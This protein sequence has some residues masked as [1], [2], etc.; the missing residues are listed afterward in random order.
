MTFAY[1]GNY[2]CAECGHE[3]TMKTRLKVGSFE[4]ECDECGV[5]AEFAATMDPMDID[6][7]GEELV[8]R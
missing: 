2:E 3:K 6:K 5:E 7:F 1:V 4:D 8:P